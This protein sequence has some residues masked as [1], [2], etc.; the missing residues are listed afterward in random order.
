MKFF[1]LIKNVYRVHGLKKIMLAALKQKPCKQHDPLHATHY[2][3]LFI[4]LLFPLFLGKFMSLSA[5]LI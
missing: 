1:S 3:S 5:P 2:T 4:L